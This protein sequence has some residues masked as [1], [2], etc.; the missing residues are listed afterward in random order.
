MFWGRQDVF[1]KRGKN[2]G[3]F[4]QC[5]NRWNNTL[6]PKQR[7]EKKYSVMNVKNTQWTPLELWRIKEHLKGTKEDG[8]DVL[9]I[10]PLL[11]DGTCRFI[12][13]DFDNHEKKVQ[14]RQIMLTLIM[15][16]MQ[17]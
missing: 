15:N 8:T 6:C 11:A 17:K 3:Y 7:G 13:F 14:N 9:G 4:P 12:V 2:G 1:A 5:N 16:G 10:Y